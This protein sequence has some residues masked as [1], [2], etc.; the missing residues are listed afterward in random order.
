[1]PSYF[2]DEIHK[3]GTR[4]WTENFFD[5]PPDESDMMH[6]RMRIEQPWVPVG[7]VRQEDPLVIET[8][9]VLETGDSVEYM[10]RNLQT[11]SCKVINIA[12]ENGGEIA[13][14]NPGNRI[15]INTD[16]VLL[17]PELNS[18]FRKKI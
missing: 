8:R 16:P 5:G 13:R 9:N 12:L 17:K 4:G 3:L 2:T 7:V 6:D 10:G 18:I 15:I 1:M 11:I 14:A